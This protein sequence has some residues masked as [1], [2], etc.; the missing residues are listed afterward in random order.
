MHYSPQDYHKPSVKL[1]VAHKAKIL[2]EEILSLRRGCENVLR[3][4]ANPAILLPF[5][6]NTWI[7]NRPER[8]GSYR[9][10][11]YLEEEGNAGDDSKHASKW[12]DGLTDGFSSDDGGSRWW[13][14]PA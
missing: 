5:R 6:I 8:R 3:R 9:Q 12:L 7:T 1:F 10:D 14:G 13:W 11:G 4:D 2:E